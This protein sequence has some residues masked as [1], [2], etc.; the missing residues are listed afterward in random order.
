MGFDITDKLGNL[1]SYKKFIIILVLAAIF[2]VTAV[3]VY[4]RYIKQSGSMIGGQNNL[5]AGGVVEGASGSMGEH[6]KNA[7]FYFFYTDWCPHCKKA[8]PEVE[9]L[10]QTY[11]NGQK[12]NGY[13]LSFVDVDCEAQPDIANEFKIEGYPTIKLI[14]GNQVID[15]DAKPEYKTF[16][17]FLSTVLAK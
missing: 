6:G 5:Q 2:I 8:K 10:K 16:E 12:I 7:Q 11:S 15:F 14:K 13:T 9:K 1:G 3:Y 17:Q 4:K